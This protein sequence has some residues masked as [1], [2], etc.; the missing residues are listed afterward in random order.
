MVGQWGEYPLSSIF[1]KM[2]TSQIDLSH[3]SIRPFECSKS[4]VIDLM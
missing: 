1:Q 4:L 3:S 2:H